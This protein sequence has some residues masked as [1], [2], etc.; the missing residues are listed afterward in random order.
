MTDQAILR[1]QIERVAR[2]GVVKMAD[3]HWEPQPTPRTSHSAKRFFLR[4][5]ALYNALAHCEGCRGY[6]DV[7][8]TPGEF[9]DAVP[10]PTCSPLWKVLGGRNLIMEGGK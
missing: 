5:D 9:D 2:F 3:G 10:C 8:K 7:S 4:P 1:E 6:G